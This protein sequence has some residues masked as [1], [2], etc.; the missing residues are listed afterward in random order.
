MPLIHGFAAHAAG[1]ELA[2]FKY[3]AGDLK[4]NEVEIDITHCGV[5]RSDIH[6]IDNDWGVSEYPFIPGH[7]IV[8]KVAATGATV[9]GLNQGDRVGVGWQ[10]ASCGYCEWCLQG[11]ENLCAESQGTCVRRHGGYAEK[12]RINARFVVTIPEALDSGRA[13]PLLCA[14]V[15]VYNPLRTHGINPT[16]RVGVIGI[17]GLG[18][19]AIQFANAFGAEITA[20]STSPVKE[21]EA[22]SLGAH[23]FVNTRDSK[24]LKNMAGTFDF[25]LSTIHWDLDWKA[26]IGALR[27]RGTLCLV[28]VPPNAVAIP[29]VALV[30]GQKLVTGSPIGSPQMIREM[31]DVSSRHN[32]QAM[33][34][35]FPMS[36]A[37]AAITKVRKNQIR[38]RAVLE[39]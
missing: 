29:G 2:P 33:V 22:R 26:Y 1:A 28:G 21:A 27:S 31:L 3:E 7:E 36:E 15:T 34:E 20:F 18:H 38:Y 24:A 13:A 6:L 35:T 5:C 16:S 11:E 10:A 30:N 14:G 23:H 9:L 25:I 19:L 12:I 8:G 32:I 4:P 17:G 37:N 39:K